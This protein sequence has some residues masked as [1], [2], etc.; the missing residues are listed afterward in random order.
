MY[1]MIKGH[2]KVVFNDTGTPQKLIIPR[3]EFQQIQEILG[4]GEEIEFSPE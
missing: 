3:A 2:K 1:H 4:L